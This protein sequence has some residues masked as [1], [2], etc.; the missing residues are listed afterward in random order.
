MATEGKGTMKSSVWVF[1]FL[2]AGCATTKTMQID[3]ET[4]E[5]QA[6]GWGND[7]Q[8]QQDALRQHD[9]R[10]AQQ[11]ANAQRDKEAQEKAQRAK[12]KAAWEDGWQAGDPVDYKGRHGLYQSAESQLKFFEEKVEWLTAEFERNGFSEERIDAWVA[13][14]DRLK[15]KYIADK[16]RTRA[17][18]TDNMG[19][20]DELQWCKEHTTFDY[21]NDPR[22]PYEQIGEQVSPAYRCSTER[23]IRD[24]RRVDQGVLLVN[25]A[26][27]V[28][29]KYSLRQ[30]NRFRNAPWFIDPREYRAAGTA[31][32][33]SPYRGGK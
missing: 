20:P 18:Q 23:G 19:D 30:V 4:I 9:E 17:F 12:I 5:Y 13:Y 2:A 3:G 6:S 11:E 29:A 33:L 28:C 7:G 8:A 24:C 15:D 1:V 27:V 22:V 32:M 14:Q 21:R 16:G 25:E 10:H 31:G 26:Q